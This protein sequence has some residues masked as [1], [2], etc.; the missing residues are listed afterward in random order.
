MPE[1]ALDEIPLAIHLGS[2]V[3]INVLNFP[4]VKIN[5]LNFPV[6]SLILNDLF[7]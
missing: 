6:L 5:V 3:K 2:V 7:I 1:Q 4:A